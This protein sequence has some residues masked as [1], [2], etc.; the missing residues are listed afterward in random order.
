M[1]AEGASQGGPMLA[2]AA[3]LA[4]RELP[5]FTSNDLVVT[6]N[7]MLEPTGVTATLLPDLTS[8]DISSDPTRIWNRGKSPPKIGLR[9]NGVTIEI[10][11]ED[12]AGFTAGDVARIDARSWRNGREL[13]GR[14]RA[15]VTVTELFARAGSGI[16]ENFDRAAAITVVT[17]AVA[18]LVDAIGVVWQ[19]SRCAVASPDLAEMLSALEKG[20]APAYL[21]IGSDQEPAPRGAPATRTVGLTSLIGVEIEVGGQGVSAETGFGMAVELAGAILRAGELPEPGEVLDF[22]RDAIFAVQRRSGGSRAITLLPSPVAPT[23]RGSSAA[24]AA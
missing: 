4:T 6:V 22:G 9:L 19:P 18:R 11:G 13:L 12:R 3:T 20:K 5:R 14:S 16:D 2:F 15:H 23:T 1:T 17:V 8:E 10:K 24:G 21:W 7:R